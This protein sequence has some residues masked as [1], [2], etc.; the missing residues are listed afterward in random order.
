MANLIRG[1]GQLGK[2][3]SNK[4]DNIKENVYIY[5]TWEVADKTRKSQEEQYLRFKKFVEDKKDEKI[6]FISTKSQK[7]TWY[8]HFKQLSEIYLLANCE[9]SKV[10]RLPTFVG[11]PSKLF[12]AGE[13]I[14]TYGKVEL[15]SLDN[16][17]DKIIEI[18]KKDTLLRIIDV[19][20]EE[21]S[22][23]LVREIVKAA[24]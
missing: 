9:N 7:E 21:I 15:I 24:K 1:R 2:K 22:A 17:A 6:V 13:E 19:D 16:A 8:T 10:I 3:L 5:H 4:I 11:S 14:K 20:G 12:S 23:R 18:C